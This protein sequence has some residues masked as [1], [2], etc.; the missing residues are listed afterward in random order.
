MTKL[1]E[2]TKR[3][4]RDLVKVNNLMRKL[5]SQDSWL[6]NRDWKPVTSSSYYVGQAFKDCGCE[7]IYTHC[8]ADAVITKLAQAEDVFGICALD[9]DFILFEYPGYYICSKTLDWEFDQFN[10][11]VGLRFEY[12]D[13]D[14]LVEKL[15]IPKI[16]LKAYACILGCDVNKLSTEGH[17]QLRQRL[18]PKHDTND[19]KY[20]VLKEIKSMSVEEIKTLRHWD[21]VCKFYTPVAPSPEVLAIEQPTLLA[22]KFD[23]VYRRGVCVEDVNSTRTCYKVLEPLRLQV[24]KRLKEEGHIAWDIIR[25]HVCHPDEDANTW[26]EGKAVDISNAQAAPSPSEDDAELLEQILEFLK[27]HIPVHYIS[28]L[29]KQFHERRKYVPQSHRLNERLRPRPEDI[30]VRN[31]FL[32]C[33]ELMC[34]GHSRSKVWN[35][36]D[37]VTFHHL[38]EDLY[39]ANV[40]PAAHVYRSYSDQQFPHPSQNYHQTYPQSH[41]SPTYHHQYPQAYQSYRNYNYDS[42]YRQRNYPY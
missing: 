7:V 32:Q 22:L 10:R 8:E 26:R 1:N 31:L 2:W 12:V 42:N 21:E 38:C 40:A 6:D 41:L 15:E 20:A 39:N 4:K 17:Q 14:F 3:R 27:D 30:H 9:T 18:C 13:K 36:F 35:I 28:I 23:G 34:L 25:E 33:W 19:I 5:S 11:V 16:Y 37:G 29:K 24:Y